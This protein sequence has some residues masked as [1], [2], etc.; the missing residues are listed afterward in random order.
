MNNVNF[1]NFESIISFPTADINTTH[2]KFYVLFI[3]AN[4]SIHSDS[5]VLVSIIRIVLLGKA[6]PECLGFGLRLPNTVDNVD[7]NSSLPL[8]IYQLLLSGLELLFF[9]PINPDFKGI[10]QMNKKKKNSVGGLRSS[11]EVWY[12]FKQLRS[13]NGLG[14]TTGHL[15]Y[16]SR[17]Y[18]TKIRTKTHYDMLCEYITSNYD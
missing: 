13:H 4:E 5:Q 14:P 17:H 11:Q 9:C 16:A 18:V 2:Q 12:H 7:S 1:E 3:L 8:R 6:L 15:R 10:V